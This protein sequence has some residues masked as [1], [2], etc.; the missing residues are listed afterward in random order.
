[1]LES[2]EISHWYVKL[3]APSGSVKDVVSAVKVEPSYII[4]VFDSTL[5]S[6]IVV[7]SILDTVNLL[8]SFP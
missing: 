8:V 1:M 3:I 6:P 7:S 5:T 2:G 4:I